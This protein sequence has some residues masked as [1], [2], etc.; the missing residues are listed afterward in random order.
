MLT[1]QLPGGSYG[2]GT[3]LH[4]TP[5][6]RKFGH[7][8][9]NVGYTCFSFAWPD[10]GAAVAVMT[11]S[12][13]TREVLTAI[14]TTADREYATA[15]AAT[16]PDDVTGRYLLRDDFPLDVTATDDGLTLTAAGWPPVVLLPLEGGRYRHPG[17]DLEI[18]FRLELMELRQ[19]GV[20]QTATRI[21]DD[22]R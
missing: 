11:N 14:L 21:A 7:T 2:L 15:E 3:E 9:E 6:H 8:G 1:P 13:D 17:L 16:P 10:T 22:R 4:D 18:G 20:T 12:E 19:E 5:G